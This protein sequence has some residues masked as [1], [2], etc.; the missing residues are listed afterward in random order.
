MNNWKNL[1]L[2][3]NDSFETAIKKL[4]EITNLLDEGSLT[5]DH[6]LTLYEEG[7]RIYQFCNQKLDKAEQKINVVLD[8]NDLSP[9]SISL[10]K[11]KEEN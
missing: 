10:D 3:N 11:L 1:K 9:Q 4:E 2:Q 8:E 7:I 5:L 6:T